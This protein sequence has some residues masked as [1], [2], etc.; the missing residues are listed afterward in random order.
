MRLCHRDI[1]GG[2]AQRFVRL[3]QLGARS[4]T[5]G[6]QRLH[7]M[8]RL[9]RISQCSARDLPL[10]V[11]HMEGVLVGGGLCGRLTQRRLRG[12]DAS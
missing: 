1:A 11:E 12:V 2:T 10:R 5:V 4:D 3:V 9:L 6:L 8:D 7:A